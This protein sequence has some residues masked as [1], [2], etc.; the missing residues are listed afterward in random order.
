MCG[1][2]V[3]TKFGRALKD[4]AN[5]GHLVLTPKGA[6]P[7]H[8]IELGDHRGLIPRAAERLR[9]DFDKSLQIESVAR[10]VK[11]SL[12]EYCPQISGKM[13]S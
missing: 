4:F 13:R 3:G 1:F 11:M 10:D 2:Q 12:P 6:R 5:C 8:I 7:W 9:S